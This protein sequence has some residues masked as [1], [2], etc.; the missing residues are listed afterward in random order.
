M[1]KV[2]VPRSDAK[3]WRY[4]NLEKFIDVIQ[5]NALWFVKVS[6]LYEIDP[7][8]GRRPTYD[9]KIERQEEDDRRKSWEKLVDSSGAK[10]DVSQR[11]EAIDMLTGNTSSSREEAQQQLREDSFVNCWHVNEYESAA[12]WKLYSNFN[13]GIAIQSTFQKLKQSLEGFTKTPISYGLVSYLD[14][15]KEGVGKGWI[16]NKHFFVKRKSFLHENELR[17]AI[18]S[19]YTYSN[20]ESITTIGDGIHVKTELD[21]LIESIYISPMAKSYFENIVKELVKMYSLNKEIIKSDL[22]ELK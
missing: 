8:E 21:K 18:F 1:S 13:T 15:K 3:I 11:K 7:Y 22:L 9:I 12:M 10:F 2:S 5:R 14:I 17:A 6:K 4:M 19:N 16:E 20:N